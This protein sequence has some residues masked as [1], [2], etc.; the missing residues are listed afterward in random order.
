MTIK[1]SVLSDQQID[2]PSDKSNSRDISGANHIVPAPSACPAR[3][4]DKR[5]KRGGT[6]AGA[7]RKPGSL[8]KRTLEVQAAEAAASEIVAKVMSESAEKEMTDRGSTISPKELLLST[9]R[10]AWVAGNQLGYEAEKIVTEAEKLPMGIEREALTAKAR[11]LKL[12]AEQQLQL[13]G[14]TARQVAPYEH[15]RVRGVPEQRMGELVI[16]GKKY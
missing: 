10:I 15:P 6:R 13:A 5:G 8:N 4:G 11:L 1:P 7:G 16:V 12:A 9:M 3:P 14:R 2:H